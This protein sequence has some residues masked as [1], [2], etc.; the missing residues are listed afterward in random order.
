MEEANHAVSWVHE[1]A[2]LPGQGAHP[3]V[4]AMLEGGCR[5]LSQPKGASQW[6]HMTCKKS[7]QV[8]QHHCQR[9]GLLQCACLPMQHS[10]LKV[11]WTGGTHTDVKMWWSVTPTLSFS[12]SVG[13]SPWH[14]MSLSVS[15]IFGFFLLLL[16]F[17][18][19][20]SMLWV[21]CLYTWK[22]LLPVTDVIEDWL[23]WKWA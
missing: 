19:C 7:L 2:G 9:S 8:Q 18:G 1:I 11:Q 12:V 10:Y 20:A 14:R 13:F 15:E 3:A 4:Q 17:N 21:A 6:C 16:L 23:E 5:L 22:L